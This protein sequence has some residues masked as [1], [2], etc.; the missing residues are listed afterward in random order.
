MLFAT[1]F[2]FTLG[3][4]VTLALAVL[5]F[6]RAPTTLVEVGIAASLLYLAAELAEASRRAAGFGRRPLAMATG[7]GLL[8]GFGFAGALAETGLPAGEI[9]LALVAFNLGIE[10]GQLAEVA[11][12]SALAFFAA[13][14][15]LRLPRLAPAYA[16]GG[17]AGYWL[18]ERAKNTYEVFF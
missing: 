10:L 11:L 5:G 3:H 16:I 2:A 4:S 15:E 7:F 17:L 14:V 18:L 12:L 6:V 1:L 8:H 9:P 13:R